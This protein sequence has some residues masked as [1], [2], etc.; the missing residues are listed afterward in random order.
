MKN[1]W[2][3]KWFDELKSTNDELLGQVYLYDNLSVVAARKQTRGR[4]QRGNSWLS[5]PGENLT[6]SFLLKPVPMLPAKDFM[7]MTFLA[8]GAVRDYLVSLGVDAIIKWPNDIY[9]RKRKICGMLIE[10][11]LKGE[12]IEYS[13]VG[14]GLNLNQTEFP[15]ELMNPT[16]VRLLTGR[17]TKPEDALEAIISLVDERL[18]QPV[19]K[20]QAN[21]L[22]SLFQKDI[23]AS[24]RDLQSGEI[25]TGIIRTVL[26]DGRLLMETASG[27]SRLYSFKEV[28]YVL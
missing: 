15:G 7:Y 6:F 16:S 2:A 5:R 4:G 21:Y 1:A 14:I 3:I 8:A 9:V 22:E 17:E 13:V 28:G 18:D 24:Y 23:S 12:G 19:E 26:P 27:E 20:L 11:G 25:F 10:N